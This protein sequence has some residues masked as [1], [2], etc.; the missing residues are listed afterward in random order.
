MNRSAQERSTGF[1]S[2]QCPL[3]FEKERERSEE[4]QKEKLSSVD[5]NQNLDGSVWSDAFEETKVDERLTINCV[6]LANKRDCFF[7]K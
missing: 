7:F 4:R 6:K 2:R 5:V 3:V 1:D